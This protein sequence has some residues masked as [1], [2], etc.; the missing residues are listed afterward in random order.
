MGQ[1]EILKWLKKHFGWYSSLQIS[2]GLEVEVGPVT[3]ALGVLRRT[4]YVF[5][6]PDPK[7]ATRILY[8]GK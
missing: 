4:G 5:S 2:R 7:H 3:R 8:K 1:D 6:R